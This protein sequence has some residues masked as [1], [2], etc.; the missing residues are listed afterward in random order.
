M[1][2]HAHDVAVA[3]IGSETQEIA[4]E[5]QSRKVKRG[6]IAQ[7][8]QLEWM[9]TT[10]LELDIKSDLWLNSH[11]MSFPPPQQ[12]PHLKRVHCGDRCAVESYGMHE[13]L[14]LELESGLRVFLGGLQS[15]YPMTRPPTKI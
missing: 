14:V 12:V 9:N 3:L 7:L 1:T 13:D 11:S 6:N 2:L 10:A 8:K 4:A 15:P 5:L